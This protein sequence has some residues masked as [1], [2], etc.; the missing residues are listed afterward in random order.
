VQLALP[1]PKEHRKKG[2]LAKVVVPPLLMLLVMVGGSFVL[3]RGV[4]VLIM[5]AG[6]LLTLVFSVT[7][8]VNDQRERKH[9]ERARVDA[10]DRYLLTRRK[11]IYRL[12]QAQRDAL[13][14]HNLSPAQIEHEAQ[15]FSS[16]LYERAANDNDFLTVSVGCSTAQTSYTL[17][18][19]TD[20]DLL[21]ADPLAAEMHELAQSFQ[22]IPDMPTVVDLKQAHLGLVGEKDPI[23]R[24]LVSLLTQLSFFHSYHDLEAILLI[25]EADRDA[26]EWV[27][28]YPH[29]RIKT[30]NVSSVISAENHRDQVLGNIAQVLKARSLKQ[31]EDKKDSRF[32]P[33]YLFV[34]DNPKLIV[35]HS[36]MEYL[37]TPDTSL[38]FSL[39]Y[40]TQLQGNL[41]DNIHTV[42]LL[43]GGDQGTLL[44]NNAELVDARVVLHEIDGID[45]DTLARRLAPIRH[46]QGIST[47]I[48][49]SVSFLDLYKVR[50]PEE[51]GVLQR[52]SANTC[53]KSLAVPLGLRGKDDVVTLN[54]HEKAHGPHGLVAGTTG[55]GKS[56]ILQSY[57]LSLAVSFHPH[58]VGF[59]LI[60]Y[61]GGGMANLFT[62]LPH[63][64]GTITNLD[65]G[66]SMRALASIRSENARRQRIFAEHGVNSINA[67]TRLFKSGEATTP[68]PHLFI[69]CDEFAELKKDQPEFMSELV[70]VARIGRSLGVHLILA[71]QKPSGVVD[72]QIWSNSRF[73]LALKVATEADSKEVLKTPDAARITQPGRAYLQVGNNEIYELFQSA[74]SGASYSEEVVEKGFDG[75]IY[76]INELGQGELL[77]DDL[78]TVDPADDSKHTQLDVVVQHVRAVYNSLTAAAVEKPWLPPLPDQ[79]VTPAISTGHDVGAIEA[80]DLEVPLGMV[81]IPERQEQTEYVHRF[82]HD[83]NLGVFGSS[84]FGKSTML[85]TTV[86]TLAS[87]NSP[88][89]FQ[90]FV[91]DYGNSALAQLRGLPHT[92]DYLG[93]DDTEKLAKLV[94]HLQ[95]ELANRKRLFAATN[96]LNFAMY[97]AMAEQSLPAILVVIDN[98]DVVREASLDLED[99]LVKLTRDGTGLGIYTSI[100]A[101]RGQA[102]RYSVLNNFKNKIALYMFDQADITAIA[103][104]CPYKLAEIRGRALVKTDDTH[105]AQCYLPVARTDDITYATQ[106]G[107]MIA[108]LADHNTAP[109]AT[110]IRILPETVTYHDLEPH[111]N[112]EAKR[113]VVGFDTDSTDPTHLDLT[114]PTQLVV[115][116]PATGKTNV[117]KLLLAQRHDTSCFIV[118]SRAGDLSDFAHQPGTVYL[119]DDSQLEAFHDHLS[120]LVRLRQE[121][122]K[123]SGQRVRDYLATQSP[124]LI[125]ID[126][127]DNFVE[128]CKPLAKEIEQTITDGKTMGF[129]FITTTVPSKLRGYD[130]LTKMLRDSQAGI[131]LGHPTD[132][133]ILAVSAPSRYKPLPDI[134]FVVARGGSRQVKIPLI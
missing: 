110:G 91:L 35:N 59:L 118:D 113:A 16:R 84:G 125:M 71:T 88:Q 66:E 120:R 104:R 54:L 62:D 126:D 134:G 44:I 53:Y 68:L 15:F 4:F 112:V 89:S 43:D 37:Q 46:S 92:A 81:D 100:T 3:G 23:R 5:A 83:G 1:K 24:Q 40:T 19:D 13:L 11:R 75:R 102:V 98:Y 76:V 111:I 77:N 25:D 32:L 63:L 70:S 58:E 51:L 41:P 47:I 80:L 6:M 122:A 18:Y 119:G 130:N 27:R 10:Y 116:N 67:Y 78:S 50:R 74:W 61:K 73:K 9:K 123:V 79:I 55:S 31:D 127:G 109:K 131:V 52:W 90:V 49:D 34:I 128:L 12:Y 21:T 103:G 124:V 57:V 117:L 121:Q 95:A 39:I 86:L 38:G 99:F 33:H 26:W 133:N 101:S 22:A 2:A 132:Q 107:S 14:Y 85:I 114:I 45:V 105:V 69:I 7:T 60:D 87:K 129:V 82:D 30:I 64:L 65:G 17:K 106:I 72:D 28:W 94:K 29:F 108:E 42:F 93:I 20:I 56:E 96:A 97:N 8:F 48:P 36:I 115:G